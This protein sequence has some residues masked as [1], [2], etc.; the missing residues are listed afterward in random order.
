MKE[1]L[2]S[3]LIKHENQNADNSIYFTFSYRIFLAC[4]TTI[5]FSVA[6]YKDGDFLRNGYKTHYQRMRKNIKPF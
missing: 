1:S 5:L 6:G 4:D 3:F 2:S